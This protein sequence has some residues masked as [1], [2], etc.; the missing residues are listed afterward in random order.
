MKVQS[1][2]YQLLRKSA[3]EYGHRN[4]LLF[5]GK[6]ISYE[7]L[8]SKVD[9]LASGLDNYGLSKGDVITFAMPNVF[10]AVFGFYA[11]SKLG[12]KCHMV[13]P[14]TPVKQMARHMD[15]TQ[16]HTLVIMDSFYDHYKPLLTNKNITIFLVNPMQEFGFFMK[17]I[18]KIINHKKRSSIHF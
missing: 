11:S 18:Y 17:T 16:S 14:I 1:T 8:I 6:Y 12:L 4:A 3:S 2:L 9:Y 5:K 10:E 7:S 13:H 15:E